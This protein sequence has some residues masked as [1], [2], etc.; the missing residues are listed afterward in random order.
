MET[1]SDNLYQYEQIV[2]CFQWEQHIIS[3]VI[4][5]IFII[6]M[7]TDYHCRYIISTLLLMTVLT[8]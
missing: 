8:E 6:F 5:Q 2:L 7:T 4:N 3:D 1:V